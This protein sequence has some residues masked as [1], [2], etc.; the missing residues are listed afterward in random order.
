MKIKMSIAEL[1]MTWSIH[2]VRLFCV[3]LRMRLLFVIAWR[4]TGGNINF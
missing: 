3:C 1:P 2:E 4:A